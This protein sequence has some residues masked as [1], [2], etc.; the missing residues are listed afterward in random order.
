MKV[1]AYAGAHNVP[2]AQLLIW[3]YLVQL[4]TNLF[5]GNMRCKNFIIT[6]VTIDLLDWLLSV[7][8]SFYALVVNW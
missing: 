3:R 4:N 6:R 2:I 1:L 8:Y 7:F 5:R